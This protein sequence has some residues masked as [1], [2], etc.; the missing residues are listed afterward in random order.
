[1]SDLSY[2]DHCVITRASETTDKWDNPIC[3]EIYNDKCDFQGGGQSFNKIMTYNDKVYLPR[4]VAVESN[5]DIVVTT[6]AGRI[7][8]GV[9]KSVND[10]PL[11]L[12]GDYVTEIEIKQSV[13]K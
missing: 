5:D 4:F 6:E 7:R 12:T 8:K 9:V 1:M 13:E 3:E 11:D 2:N 10:L